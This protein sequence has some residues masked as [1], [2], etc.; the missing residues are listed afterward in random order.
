MNSRRN[1]SMT[2][3]TVCFTGH[4]PDKVGGYNEDNDTAIWV[5]AALSRMI[6]GAI[7]K[8]TTTFISGMALGVDTWAAEAVLY[9]RINAPQI[10]L[11]AA[12]P[13]AR[14]GSRWR[15]PALGRWMSILEQSNLVY[16]EGKV[17]TVDTIRH[18]LGVADNYSTKEVSSLLNRRNE[19]MVS[20]SL[21]VIAIWDGSSGGTGNCVEYALRKRRPVCQINPITREIT[22]IPGTYQE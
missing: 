22:K 4:R 12:V 14:Q 3:E 10:R 18:L 6:R 1:A 11:I 20:Q 21:G 8:G 2:I 9:E 16:N 5:K 7:S 19:F 15:T 13:F 17:T